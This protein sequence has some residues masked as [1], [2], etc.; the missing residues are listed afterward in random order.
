MISRLIPI[1]LIMVLKRKISIQKLYTL[2][3]N[4]FKG[5]I[6]KKDKPYNYPSIIMLEPTNRCNLRCRGCAFQLKEGIAS[7]VDRGDMLLERYK[8]IIDE[9]KNHCL[10]LFLYMGGEPFLHK[11]IFDM[12]RYASKNRIFTIIATNGSFNHIEN[13]GKKVI[14]SGL[15]L[16]IVS[17]SGTKHVFY[18]KFHQFGDLNKVIKNI[19]S[20]KDNKSFTPRLTLRYLKTPENKTDWTN[21]ASFARD[22]KVDSFEMRHIDGE[23][24]LKENFTDQNNKAYSIKTIKR[25]NCFWLWSTTVVRANGDV[26]PCCFDYYGVPTLGK[27][28]DDSTIQKIWTGTKYRNFRRAWLSNKGLEYCTFCE[29][30]IG[31]QD[32]ASYKKTNIFVKKAQDTIQKKYEISY[33]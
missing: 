17:I 3:L 6:L 18:E 31:F 33:Q 8:K 14:N 16:L 19:S 29:S 27:T 28:G 15:D 5:Y 30:R 20:L 10:L 1:F 23:L 13:F 12:I 4:F 9:V 21:F 7:S 25:N 24:E 32:N 22:L 2:F 26:I 11:E